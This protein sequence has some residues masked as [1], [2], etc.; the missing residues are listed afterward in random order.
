MGYKILTTQELNATDLDNIT[1]NGSKI[2]AVPRTSNDG[3]EH[4]LEGDNYNQYTLQGILEY[5]DNHFSNWNPQI[6]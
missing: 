5:I 2:V 4:I 6:P 3:L 1:I